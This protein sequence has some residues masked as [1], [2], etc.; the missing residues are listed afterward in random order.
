[1]LKKT[2][3][4]QFRHGLK[5]AGL[6][7]VHFEFQRTAFVDSQKV[8]QTA[9]RR[10]LNFHSLRAYWVV[11]CRNRGIP[12]EIIADQAGHVDINTTK[13]YARYADEER[14][15]ILDN[16]YSKVY[17]ETEAHVV[18]A[19]PPDALSTPS[20]GTALENVKALDFLQMQLVKGNISR[21]QYVEKIKLLRL[22]ENK[23]N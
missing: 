23:K 2:L 8:V 13:G 20:Q 21:E 14:D 9:K 15:R 11:D 19:V 1:M 6:D 7:E 18:A 5:L 12:I 10:K 4:E 3:Y 16:A 17:L 22:G